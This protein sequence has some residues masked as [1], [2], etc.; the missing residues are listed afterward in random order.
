MPGL[1]RDTRLI[2]ILMTIKSQIYNLGHA[3]P[4]SKFLS[5][6][7]TLAQTIATLLTLIGRGAESARTFFK[8][9]FLH[10]I[11]GLE[12]MVFTVFWGYVEGAG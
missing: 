1:Q 11:R 8:H 3:M 12:K 7:L 4:R 2:L 9:P 5:L 10:E 6:S